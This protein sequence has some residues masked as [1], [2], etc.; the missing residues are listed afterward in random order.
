MN[1]KYPYVIH[2]EHRALLNAY[3]KKLTNSTLYTTEFPCHECA[4]LVASF[5]IK[6]IVYLNDKYA[7]SEETQASKKL[8][9]LTEIEL[10]DFKN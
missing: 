10:I 8:L 2:A 6:K 9:K 7:D 1:T 3:G 4:K 5:G